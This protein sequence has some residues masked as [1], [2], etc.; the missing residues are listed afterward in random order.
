VP[1]AIDIAARIMGNDLYRLNVVSQNLANA[2]T[3]GFKKEYVVARPFVEHLE[4]GRQSLQIELPMQASALDTRQGPL[5]RTGNALDVALEGAGFFELSGPDGAVYS[6]HG[7]FR[8]DPGGRLVS[9]G[10]L[11]VMGAAGEIQLAG[12]QPAIDALGRV[13]EG[14]RQVAQLKIMRFNDAAALAP[15]GGGLYRAAGS[16][17]AASEA[18]QVRQGFLESSNVASLG[19]MLT[20]VTLMR[21][22][23]AASRVVQGYDGMLGS[24]I[25][26]GEF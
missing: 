11:P 26:I 16:G 10:G 3:T 17:E 19:E 20:L 23:E 13:F 8:V 14:D 2:G 7:S 18:L 5:V 15:L 12:T 9:S 25:R 1:S 24:A 6:R 4:A 22:F 21:R